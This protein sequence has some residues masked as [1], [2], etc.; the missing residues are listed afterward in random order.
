MFSLCMSVIN[1]NKD[2]IP[3]FIMYECHNDS[4][5]PVSFSMYVCHNDLIPLEIRLTDKKVMAD[6][7]DR[8]FGVALWWMRWRCV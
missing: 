1:H 8:G 6:V 3:R 5:P 2:F 7:N 4:I